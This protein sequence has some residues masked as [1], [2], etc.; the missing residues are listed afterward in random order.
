MPNLEL[1]KTEIEALI[2]F[3]LSSKPGTKEASTFP[4][5]S[6]GPLDGQPAS[7]VTAKVALKPAE[8]FFIRAQGAKGPLVAYDV[9]NNVEYFRLPPGM[10]AA[11]G[12]H[13]YAAAPQQNSTILEVF[14]PKT[15]HLERRFTLTGRWSLSGVSPTGRWLALTRLPSESEQQ[16]WT[17]AKR[18]ETE[19]QIIDATNGEV[20]H[21]MQLDGNFEVE[22]ISAAGDA[23]FL[24]EHLPAINPTQYLIRL[25]DL[26]AERLQPDPLRAKTADDK[27]MTGLAWGGV[28]SPDGRWLLTLYLNTSRK[29]AFI[30]ALNLVDKFPVCIDLPSGEGDFEQLEYYSLTLDPNGRTVYAANADLGIVAEVSLDNFQV[31][32]KSEFAASAST[33]TTPEAEPEAPTN[34]SVL[35]KDGQMLYFTSGRDVWGYNTQ[36]GEVS[37][38]YLSDTPIQSLGLSEDNQRLYVATDQQPLVLDL[39][40]LVTIDSQPAIAAETTADHQPP[41]WYELAAGGQDTLIGSRLNSYL[42]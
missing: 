21:S 30:H 3:L 12:S 33:E 18:W 14:E 17:Q 7:S 34:Y 4:A 16:A 31:I 38:P 27:L 6:A 41:E 36:S 35:S 5:Q 11:D 42:S 25:Y 1:K 15:S 2:A 9:A 29:M 24:I 23:L 13:Y 39:A 40:K 37:G 20:A 8:L 26:S 10:P 28:A 22:T 32:R 19:I